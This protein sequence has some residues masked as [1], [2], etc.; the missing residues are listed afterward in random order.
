MEGVE[1]AT[2]NQMQTVRKARLGETSGNGHCR[3]PGDV[4]EAGAP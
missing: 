1:G 3:Q 2:P 4:A